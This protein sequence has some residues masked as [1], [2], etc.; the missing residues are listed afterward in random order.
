MFRYNGAESGPFR[1]AD[2]L[3]VA[4][5]IELQPAESKGRIGKRLNSLLSTD[6]S[7]PDEWSA[8]RNLGPLQ[9][10]RADRCRGFRDFEVWQP[11]H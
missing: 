7:T 4:D 10:R 9:L 5:T 6:G 3:D 8:N 1:F 2:D 11:E